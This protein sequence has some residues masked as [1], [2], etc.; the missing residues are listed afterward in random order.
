MRQLNEFGL[1][2]EVNYREI[3]STF[4]G[5]WAVTWIP[6]EVSNWLVNGL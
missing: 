4:Q 1:Y 5:V 6:Q 3:V 2:P